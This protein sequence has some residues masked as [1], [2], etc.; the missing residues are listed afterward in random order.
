MTLTIY[1]PLT[2]FLIGVLEISIFVYS[3]MALSVINKNKNY[4]TD[5]SHI[6]GYYIAH[7]IVQGLYIVSLVTSKC[8][9]KGVFRFLMTVIYYLSLVT[10]RTTIYSNISCITSYYNNTGD[11]DY[12]E[13]FYGGTDL[14]LISF[15]NMLQWNII[16]SNICFNL[17]LLSFIYSQTVEYFREVENSKN[18]KDDEHKLDY[19]FSILY[20]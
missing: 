7:L 4:I 20:K 13:M 14:D 6:Y 1:Y 11:D 5:C 12:N 19:P 10:I 17:L 16:A 8:F 15:F 9:K 3:I 2:T 18:N